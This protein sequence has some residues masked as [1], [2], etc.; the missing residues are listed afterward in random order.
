MTYSD[1]KDCRMYSI[2]Y[3]NYVN[4]EFIKDYYKSFQFAMQRSQEVR[5]IFY[6]T[7]KE[8]IYPKGIKM[9]NKIDV[10]IIKLKSIISSIIEVLKRLF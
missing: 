1:Y 9:I 2:I 10:I 3:A 4:K 7:L 6:N 8:I 5:Y